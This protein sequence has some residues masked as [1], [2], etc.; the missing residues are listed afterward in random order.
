M[1]QTCDMDAIHT[2]SFLL[3]AISHDLGHPGVNNPFLVNTMDR[4]AIRYNDKSILENM[5]VAKAYQIIQQPETNI[6]AEMEPEEFRTV[7]HLMIS[8]ILATDMS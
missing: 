2:F 3:A 7:R 6:F 4:L 1:K 8:C 5:H